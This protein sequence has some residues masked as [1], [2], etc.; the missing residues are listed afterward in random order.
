MKETFLRFALIFLTTT[1]TVNNAGSAG[2]DVAVPGSVQS[3][4]TIYSLGVEWDLTGDANHNAAATLQYRM[5]G[6]SAW[7]QAMPLVRVDYGGRNMLAGSILFLTPNTT[8]EVKLDLSDPDGGTA[9]QTISVQT[10]PLP[11]LPTGGRTL[12]VAPGTGSGN[13][14]A[15]NPYKGI[16][17]A[18]TAAQPGDIMLL[19]AG[20]YGGGRTAFTK[21]GTP[22]NYLVWKGA[23][24]G[25]V[26]FAGLDVSASYLWIEGIT[27]RNQPFAL[28]AT[29]PGTTDNVLTRNTFLNNHY[30]I[31]LQKGGSYWYIADNVIVGDTPASTGSLD[32]EGIE[33]MSYAQPS[34]GHTVAYNSITNVADGISSPG[35]NTDIFG[36]DIFD[37]SDDG[38][39]ADTGGP[40]VLIW[41]NR[42]HNAFHH[43]FSFQPQS[44]APWYIIRNQL[45]GYTE[46]LLKFRQTDRFVLMHNTIVAWDSLMDCCLNRDDILK[47]FSRNNLWISVTGGPIWPMDNSSF[48]DWRADLDYDG[49]DWGGNGSPFKYGGQNY[50]SLATFSAA[51]GLETHGKVIQ[52]STCFATFNV[53]G[54]PPTPIPAQHM[55]LNAS[56][57]AVD[58][59]AVLP[60]INDGFTGSAPDLGAYELGASLPHY[61]P[62]DA[63]PSDTT[64]P[65]APR[66]LRIQ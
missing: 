50:S 2:V 57:N 40:N 65:S 32:G 43:H 36:N 34:W 52:H 5:E 37:V 7:K 27:I 21:P 60:N 38:I 19:H 35:Y 22:G 16:A 58:A 48:K 53:P 24:D 12:H 11:A 6:A 41:G 4:S 45:V 42:I 13:G 20:S 8:Y 49:F 47:A 46:N 61:G 39:E 66:N 56:C 25:E 54:A 51:S 44:G 33:M 17:A 9:S 28:L 18:Q 23:G 14:T 55:T 31:T 63:S 26:N 29:S 3:Y 64:P 15:A 30:A 1:A 62:R 59:G 10:R